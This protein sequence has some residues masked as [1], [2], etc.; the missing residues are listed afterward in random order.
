MLNDEELALPFSESSAGDNEIPAVIREIAQAAGIGVNGDAPWDI[1]IHDPAVYHAILTRG[2]VGLGESYMSGLWD[3][4]RLDH[5]FYRILRVEGD[6]HLANWAKLRLFAELIRHRIFN[7]QSPKRAFQVGE[8]H[9]DIGNDIFE[10]MLDSTMS[11]SCAYW[12]K[13]TTLEE[14]QQE[15]LDLICRKLDL[16]PGECLLDIGCGWGGLAHYAATQYGVQ[17]VG[18]TISKE[19]QKIAQARCLGLPVR[20]DLMD[21]RSLTGRYDK[22]V[23][24]GMFEH[25]GAK[26]YASYFDVVSQLLAPDGLFLLHT[27]GNYATAAGTDGWIDKYIFPNGKLPSSLEITKNL[28]RRFLIEDWH[29]FGQDYDRTL[30]A[31]WKNFEKNWPKLKERYDQSFYRMWKYYLMCC[32]GF[33]RSR[34]GQLWQL[35]LSKRQR[36]ETYRSVR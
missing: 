33:F 7:L 20:I 26:N 17:V 3:C 34:Q 8:R 9:Y 10:A 31:W 18:I 21:Y 32:A 29:N 22:I 4:E 24:V 35:V 25:V 36:E 23:S 13:A 5:F 16:R 12:S 6:E 15:K 2:S 27:I 19:Q 1:Q 14:A 30:L 11:Y 28:E